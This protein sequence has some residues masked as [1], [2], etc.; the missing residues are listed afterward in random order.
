VLSYHLT[1]STGPDHAKVFYVEVQL[2]GTPIGQGQG[3]SK[4]EAEQMAAKAG[5]AFLGKKKK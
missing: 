4:K 1:G 5:I 3:H 2:N